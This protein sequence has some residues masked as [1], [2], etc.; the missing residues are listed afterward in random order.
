MSLALS[1]SGLFISLM[2]S[3]NGAQFLI[4]TFLLV[5]FTAA[6]ATSVLGTVTVPLTSIYTSL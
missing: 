3:V 5:S 6:G 1:T 4:I 2:Q